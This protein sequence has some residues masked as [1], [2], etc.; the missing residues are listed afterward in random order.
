M[1]VRSTSNWNLEMLV[2]E[3]LRGGGG[4]GETGV[5]GEKPLGTKDRTNNKLNPMASSPGFEPGQHWW[6]AS[7][8]T[9]APSLATQNHHDITKTVDY[10]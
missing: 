2:I 6:E 7:A 8:L 10:I 1:S 9:T 3:L 5:P 4:G